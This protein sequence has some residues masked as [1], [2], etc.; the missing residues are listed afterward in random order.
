MDSPRPTLPLHERIR[1]EIEGG[2]LSGRLG[3]GER[4]PVEHE[5]MERFGCSRMTVSKAVTALVAAGLI[6]RRKRA[7]SFV[8]R[9]RMHSM[10]LAVPDLA[11][12]IGRRGQAYDFVLVS[13]ANRQGHAGDLSVGPGPA[14]EIVG[15]HRADA[16]PLAVEHRLVNLAV[17]PD[18][19]GASFEHEPPGTWLLHHIPWTEAETRIAAT[20]AEGEV[21]KLLGVGEGTPLLRIE[22]RTWRGADPVTSVRQ[23]F[24]ASAYDLVARFGP[25]AAS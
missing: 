6:E 18:I 9:P 17:V 19:G 2:I 1:R 20:G 23:H 22:R 15:V 4:L 13:S 5:L 24:L 11:E 16:A 8:A 25:S 3:P 21:A 12:E 7:G 10:V 14:L